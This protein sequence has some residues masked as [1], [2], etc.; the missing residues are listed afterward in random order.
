VT[1]PVITITRTPFVA[2]K[3]RG[4]V[5]ADAVVIEMGVRG[6]PG[7]KGDPGDAGSGGGGV[8]PVGPAGPQ[9]P[10]G[11]QGPPGATGPQGPAGAQGDTGDAGPQGPQGV[12]GPQGP[13]GATGAPGPTGPAGPQGVAGPQGEPGA[14]VSGAAVLT[15]PTARI[16]HEETVAAVG[17]TPSS[18]VVAW[19]AATADDDENDPEMTDL[20]TLWARPLTDE[21]AIGVTFSTPASG[22][23][24]LNWSAF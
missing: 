7:P 18:R 20:V 17:V 4:A 5:P 2:V 1:Q 6:P 24:N 11:I 15:L 10:Q 22:P 9:G 13:A 21:I 14:G 19:L 12:A 23:I 16:E 8:G 3:S